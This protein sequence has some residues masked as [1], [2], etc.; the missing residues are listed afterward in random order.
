MRKG[1]K[2]SEEMK[3]RLSE[4]LTGKKLDNCIKEVEKALK[5]S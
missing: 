4:K 5:Q 2:C 3:Q 1:L